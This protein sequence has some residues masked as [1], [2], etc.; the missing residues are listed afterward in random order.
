MDRS[1]IPDRS[2]ALL[3]R[4]RRRSKTSISSTVWGALTIACSIRGIDARADIYALGCVAYF[5]LTGTLVFADDNPMS[6]ALK[7]VQATPDLPSSRSELPIPVAMEDVVMRCL[8]KKP[9]DRPASARE[10]A[11][12]LQACD[13]PRWTD[14]DA[15]GWWQRHL[16]P[17]SSLRS[18][19]QTV[20]VPVPLIRKA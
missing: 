14:E 2:T 4:Y 13:I 7:H 19:A 17:T 1:W 11:V 20:S 9:E 16:P 8:A 12:L 18:F 10:V 3:A 5:L 6:M 15:D